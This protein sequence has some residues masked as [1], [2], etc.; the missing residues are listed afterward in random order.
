[1]MLMEYNEAEVMELFRED[2][3]REGALKTLISLVQDGV[4]SVED[5]A[6]RAGIS[7][8]EFEKLLASE[9]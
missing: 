9:K 3:K 1:M 4:L 8:E 5:A 6:V 2:G 7:T